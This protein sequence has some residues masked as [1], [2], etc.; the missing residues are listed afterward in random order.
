MFYLYG[1]IQKTEPV[2][3]QK[4]TQAKILSFKE[5]YGLETEKISATKQVKATVSI[6]D[7]AFDLK[8]IFETPIVKT[9]LKI[10]PQKV[11]IEIVPE[12]TRPKIKKKLKVGLDLDFEIKKI[13]G[14]EPPTAYKVEVKKRQY[15]N[16]ERIRGV[17]WRR[18][19]SKP[20][21]EDDAKRYG[22]K[23]VDNKAKASF[24]LVPVEG[25]PQKPKEKLPS[26][27]DVNTEF[28]INK[29]GI[30]VEHNR[31]RIDSPGE[32]REIT[33]LG[34]IARRSGKGKHGRKSSRSS[35][36]SMIKNM[37]KKRRF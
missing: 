9:K 8:Y 18:L 20:M 16:G 25:K 10:T 31:S 29:K 7:T 33:R 24:R 21:T 17:E 37:M 23:Y 13:I 28:Y 34:N 12:K 22:A 6:T 1:L 3:L 35:V 36:N 14:L 27:L 4:T 5:I 26:L 19:R 11:P 30:M 32:I 15:K 2:T